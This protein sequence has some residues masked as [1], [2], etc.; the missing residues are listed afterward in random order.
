M[1][2]QP[3]AVPNVRVPTLVVRNRAGTGASTSSKNASQMSS[4]HS[5]TRTALPRRDLDTNDAS[6]RSKSSSMETGACRSGSSQG[7]QP[8]QQ[9]NKEK[10]KDYT[11]MMRAHD[12]RAKL[13][14]RQ[15]TDIQTD[16]CLSDEHPD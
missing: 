3:S 7:K 16:K 6:Q 1:P 10:K 2:S 14:S 8:Q 15:S 11:V 4:S 9:Q 12:A 13:V 5:S